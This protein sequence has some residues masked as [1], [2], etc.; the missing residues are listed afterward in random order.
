MQV[1]AI[2]LERHLELQVV[3]FIGDHQL[4]DA[5]AMFLYSAQEDTW[6]KAADEP[7]EEL[8]TPC[9]ENHEIGDGEGL[10]IATS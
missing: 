10:V 2:H 3:Y 4:E 9:E 7:T 8:L 1:F 5:T 6:A